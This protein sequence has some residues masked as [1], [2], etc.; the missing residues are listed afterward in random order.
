MIWATVSSWSCF[1]W[2]CR[3]SPSLAAKNIIHLI[4]VLTIWWRPCVEPFLV[5]LKDGVC[6]DQ[7][8][9]LCPASFCIPRPNLPVTTGS[10][11][12][13]TVAFQSPIIKRKSFLGVGSQRS[14]KSSAS[15]SSALLVMAQTWITVILNGLSWKWK[16]FILSFLRLHP[17]TAFQTLLVT[18]MATPFLLR[19]SCPQ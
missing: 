14:C 7:C 9:S 5:L 10:S 16:E 12:L 2:L 13:S 19:D 1:C 8:V 6:Y 18:M 4:L 3:A 17:N 11:L 15:A